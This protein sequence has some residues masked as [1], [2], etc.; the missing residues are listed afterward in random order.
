METK[1]VEG[2]ESTM[3]YNTETEKKKKIGDIGILRGGIKH[4]TRTK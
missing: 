2:S 4:G 1:V 3:S